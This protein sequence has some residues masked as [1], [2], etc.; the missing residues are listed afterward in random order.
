MLTEKLR[1]Y[2]GS[3]WC[4]GS[5]HGYVNEKPEKITL[6]GI[7][8]VIWKS[9]NGDFHALDN[10]C[11]HAGASLG[12]GGKIHNT[13]DYCDDKTLPTT[14]LWCP[15]HGHQVQFLDDGRAI[16]E[17]VVGKRPI[18]NK[19]KLTIQDG[20]VWTY[21]QTKELVDGRFVYKD[22]EQKAP[23]PNYSNLRFLPKEDLPFHLENQT[24]NFSKVETVN[25]NIALPFYNLHDGE[26]FGGSHVQSM[27]TEKI[28]IKELV[29]DE[30]ERSWI[31]RTTKKP[32]SETKGNPNDRL[33]QD[34]FYQKFYTYTPGFGINQTDIEPQFGIISKRTI[35]SI[36]CMYPET[37]DKTKIRFERYLSKPFTRL[38]T[39]LQLPKKFNNFSDQI[40]DED[41]AIIDK[42]YAEFDHKI[43]LKN[44]TP[45]DIAMEYLKSF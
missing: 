44:D 40:F 45:C 25:Q 35:F 21:G 12:D 23:I 36:L 6:L 1:M 2:E 34:K 9:E 11:P 32:K 22:I 27:M 17:G 28:E 30:H 43:R 10:I 39:L 13:T 18:Q 16:V 4:L 37:I 26:H 19:L 7:D 8:Y 3:P 24:H 14:C 15:Y 5:V 42:A 31:L 20:L 29:V 38:E 33:I 41:M